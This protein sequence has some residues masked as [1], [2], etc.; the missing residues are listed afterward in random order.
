MCVCVCVC[1]HII[2][3]TQISFLEAFEYIKLKYEHN[4]LMQILISIIFHII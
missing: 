3:M 2:Y 4:V 1:F